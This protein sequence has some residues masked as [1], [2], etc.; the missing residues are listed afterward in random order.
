[1]TKAVMKE[2]QRPKNGCARCVWWLQSAPS[3]WGRCSVHRERTWYEHAACCEYE[4]DGEVPDNIMI[5]AD[6]L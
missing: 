5:R 3:G 4:R 1:M 6:L 2:Q